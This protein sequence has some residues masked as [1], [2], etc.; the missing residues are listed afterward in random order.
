MEPPLSEFDLI[1]N[2][3]TANAMAREEVLIGIGDDA[4]LVDDHDADTVVS[5]TSLLTQPEHLSPHI[6]G[7]RLFER[8]AAHLIEF[9]ANPH[10]AT[11][12]LSL[13]AD[14]QVWCEAFAAGLCQAARNQGVALI[15]GDTT[16]GPLTVLLTLHGYNQRQTTTRA[17]RK[18]QPSDI[19]DPLR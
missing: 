5:V 15:G 7:M 4:A 3:F 14:H 1:E 9:G 17:P 16:S 10:W 13:P 19:R 2:C 11:L 6:C 8:T 12:V 18:T